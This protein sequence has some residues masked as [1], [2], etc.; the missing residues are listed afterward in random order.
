MMACIFGVPADSWRVFAW[1]P[2]RLWDLLNRYCGTR[3]KLF[4]RDAEFVDDTRREA[5][6]RE[7][8][9]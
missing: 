9:G 7:Y 6:L 4:G 5:R 3:W 1:Y 2:C 8:L